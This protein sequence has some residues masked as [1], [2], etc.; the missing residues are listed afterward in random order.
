MNLN[1]KLYRKVKDIT[2]EEREEY[3]D[4]FATAY[5]CAKE[6]DENRICIWKKPSMKVG[7]DFNFPD[8]L[9]KDIGCFEC[10]GYKPECE[11]YLEEKK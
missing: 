10:S 3:L 11:Y 4:N 7:E 5:L 2:H 6:F 1:D 8:V 9:Y